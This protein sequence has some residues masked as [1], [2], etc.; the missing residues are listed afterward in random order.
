V[1][2]TVAD[3]CAVIFECGFMS[4]SDI[5][6]CRSEYIPRCEDD[7]GYIDIYVLCTADCVAGYAKSRSC[8][9]H[10]TCSEDCWEDADC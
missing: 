4:G 7:G 8:A 6:T 9:I 3:A 1:P 2:V 5:D 10:I